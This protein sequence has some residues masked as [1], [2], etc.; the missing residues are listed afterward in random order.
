MQQSTTYPDKKAFLE[1]VGQITGIKLQL[2]GCSK[3]VGNNGGSVFQVINA[4]AYVS[5][6][7]IQVRDMSSE[8]NLYDVVTIS[9]GG[10]RSHTLSDL[11][12]A[13][14]YTVFLFPYDASGGGVIG[15]PSNL[16]VVATKED[17]KT[18]NI[19]SNRLFF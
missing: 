14:E 13:T 4:Q 12:P 7:H 2:T 9:G 3:N 10:T 8:D 16:K 6:F 19:I 18:F 15:T 11:R 5:G 1:K 17:G